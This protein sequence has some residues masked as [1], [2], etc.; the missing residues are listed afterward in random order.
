MPPLPSALSTFKKDLAVNT[1]LPSEPFVSIE[2]EI[3]SLNFGLQDDISIK[4]SEVE[5]Y[6]FMSQICEEY[7]LEAALQQYPIFLATDVQA[8]FTSQ[9]SEVFV[10]DEDTQEKL[11]FV[12]RSLYI[13]TSYMDD[14][15][16]EGETL[17]VDAYFL[18]SLLR[19]QAFERL[20]GL[21]PPSS[22]FWAFANKYQ[23]RSIAG[24]RKK[25]TKWNKPTS[26]SL[27]EAFKIASSNASTAQIV[28]TALACLSGSSELIPT[29]EKSLEAFFQGLQFHNDLKNWRADF[30][31]G[32]YSYL[33][34]QII[35]RKELQ[36]KLESVTLEELARMIYFTGLAEEILDHAID[37]YRQAL[38]YVHQVPCTDWKITIDNSISEASVLLRNLQRHKEQEIDRVSKLVLK[39]Q[40]PLEAR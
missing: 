2:D 8:S 33:L 5:F 35:E 25:R 6:Q 39:K 11:Y 28:T 16:D 26:Y 24:I 19:D 29:L 15:F 7:G 17:K 9:F 21:F 31:S 38:S 4:K 1:H 30:I 32:R 40:K 14:V 13:Y 20:N 23:R 18:A 22:D 27:D 10:L 3:A 12:N 36:K 34:C 37:C